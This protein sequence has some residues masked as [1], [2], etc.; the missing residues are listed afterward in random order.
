MYQVVFD[1]VKKHNNIILYFV[2]HSS[3]QRKIETFI[4]DLLAYLTSGET[5][6]HDEVSLK[7]KIKQI[8]FTKWTK[9][10]KLK[11]ASSS[12]TLPLTSHISNLQTHVYFYKKKKL[13]LG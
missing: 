1:S 13:K 3:S 8:H 2:S 7:T 10:K 9:M 12:S 6:G 5:S 11:S 4:D